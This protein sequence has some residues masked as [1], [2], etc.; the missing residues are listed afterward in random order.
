MV[1]VGDVEF[2]VAQNFLGVANGGRVCD[3]PDAI[4]DLVIVDGF[5]SRL[6]GGTSEDWA[7]RFWVKH[8]DVALLRTASAE[9]GNPVRF[10]FR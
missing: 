5:D 1:A 3:F 6:A 7:G 4:G 2:G 10:G 9:E 8:E